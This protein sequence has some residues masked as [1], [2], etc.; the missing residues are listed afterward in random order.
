MINTVANARPVTPN[1]KV[2]RGFNVKF[3]KKPMDSAL[4]LDF[5]S[6]NAVEAPATSKESVR[7]IEPTRVTYKYSMANGSIWGSE[8]NNATSGRAAK[9]PSKNEK[10]L[11]PI[12][13]PL[14]LLIQSL[15]SFASPRPAPRS[16]IADALACSPIPIE[17]N[18]K[19]TLAAIDMP[20]RD[21]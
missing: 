11:N 2:K 6:P 1:P 10:T 5:V 12:A 20:G 19:K 14:T 7:P 4:R 21:R 15:T 17:S 18:K 13:I 8:P 3:A 9:T 16:I